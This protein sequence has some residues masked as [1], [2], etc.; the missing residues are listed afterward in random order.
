MAKGL[1][2]ELQMGRLPLCHYYITFCR[3]QEGVKNLQFVPDYAEII[4]ERQFDR[5]LFHEGNPIH[6]G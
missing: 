3:E 4:G 2:A 1:E 6:H 5:A